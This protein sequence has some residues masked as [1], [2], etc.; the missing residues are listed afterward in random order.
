MSDFRDYI[1]APGTW[2]CDTKHFIA[3]FDQSPADL[4][5]EWLDK[6]IDLPGEIR[7]SMKHVDIEVCFEPKR[8]RW[9]WKRASESYSFHEEEA[10]YHE[11][12]EWREWVAS[13]REQGK[14]HQ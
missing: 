5:E 10:G 7:F 2:Y 9:S 13:W 6:G 11:S 4:V 12:F 8:H 14:V 1:M 3:K